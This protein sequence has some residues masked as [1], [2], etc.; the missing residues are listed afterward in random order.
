MQEPP[1]LA[2]ITLVSNILHNTT[3]PNNKSHIHT[4]SNTHQILIYGW[5]YNLDKP[6]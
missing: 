5:Y 6:S 2:Q 4:P 3:D 1:Y